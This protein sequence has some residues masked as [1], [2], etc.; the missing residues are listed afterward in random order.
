MA[1]SVFEFCFVLDCGEDINKILILSRSNIQSD[2]LSCG[3]QLRSKFDPESADS[4]NFLL[5]KMKLGW[6]EIRKNN[7]NIFRI[8]FWTNPNMSGHKIQKVMVQPINLLFR[9][10]QKKLRVQVIWT[11]SS[12]KVLIGSILDLVVW[13]CQCETWRSHYRIWW[14]HEPRLGWCRRNPRQGES[15]FLSHKTRVTITDNVI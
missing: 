10:F 13:R 8:E 6:I 2:L 1:S 15:S 9:F 5:S 14:I 12:F 7:E 11:W 3:Q 4:I